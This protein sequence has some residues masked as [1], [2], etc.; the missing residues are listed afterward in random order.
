[1]T[2][3]GV[4][5]HRRLGGLLSHLFRRMSK[6]TSELR[7]TSLCEGNSPV[8]GE[9]PSQKAINTENNSIW[10][11]HHVCYNY[12]NRSHDILCIG[13]YL[14]IAFCRLT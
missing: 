11:H 2:E 13:G 1:M 5:N 7:V 9:I 10:W 8:T 3:V 6:K 4:S 14:F 12:D